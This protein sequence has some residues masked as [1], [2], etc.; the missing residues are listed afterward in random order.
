MGQNKQRKRSRSASKAS[1][2]DAAWKPVT[3]TL[4]G[5][6]S[7]N[8]DADTET[9]LDA[10]Q[11]EKQLSRNHY[12]DPKLSRKAEIDLPMNPGEDCAMFYGLE[13]LDASQYQVVGTGSSKRLIITGGVYDGNRETSL[14]KKPHSSNIGDDEGQPTRKKQKKDK[15]TPKDD[16]VNGKEEV[17]DSS[18]NTKKMKKAK[19]QHGDDG[20]QDDETILS[21]HTEDPQPLTI[22]QLAKIQSSWSESSGGAHIH[23]RLL[24]SLYRLGFECPTPIQAATLAAA[25]MGRRN[26]VG[27]APTGSGESSSKEVHS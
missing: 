25:I 14:P 15:K 11:D 5:E 22:D 10:D 18:E 6:N 9:K 4:L 7:S 27:A 20:Q 3:V 16:D 26:L 8:C 13:V 24:E 17:A 19:N 21:L 1:T 12:D 2:A 23:N